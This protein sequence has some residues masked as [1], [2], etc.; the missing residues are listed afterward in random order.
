[1]RVGGRYTDTNVINPRSAGIGTFDA[2]GIVED[3]GQARSGFE[4]RAFV[5]ADSLDLHSGPDIGN[6]I[7]ERL[8]RRQN[9]HVLA[10][11][12]DWAHVDIDE[13]GQPV[14]YFSSRYLIGA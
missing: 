7:V 1:M 5:S 11:A 8:K 13:D 2:N 9:V 3:V 6:E 4:E 12:D 10:T 14:G